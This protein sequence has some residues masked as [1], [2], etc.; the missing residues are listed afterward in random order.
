MT[1]RARP[2]V[3]VVTDGQPVDELLV[4]FDAWRNATAS[5]RGE[6]AAYMEVGD[7][8]ITGDAWLTAAQVQRLARLLARDASAGTTASGAVR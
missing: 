7:D 3:H 2:L 5:G 1:S 6:P 8:E 4:A